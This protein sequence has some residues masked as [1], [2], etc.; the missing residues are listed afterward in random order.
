MS[1]ESLVDCPECKKPKLIRLIGLGLPPI[2]KGT[3]TP[4]RGGRGITKCKDKL[5]EGKYKGKKP[6]W[7]SGSVNKKILKNP[8]RYIREGK[9]D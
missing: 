8:E 5:G 1:E 9:V 2:I 6:F 3:K 7:R 4:C